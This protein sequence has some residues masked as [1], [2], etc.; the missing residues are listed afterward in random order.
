MKKLMQLFSCA[1]M[2]ASDLVVEM[3]YTSKTPNDI[4][5]RNLS[6]APPL[7]SGNFMKSTA[8]I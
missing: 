5:A 2:P 6:A 3:L 4:V 8:M 7:V 1:V